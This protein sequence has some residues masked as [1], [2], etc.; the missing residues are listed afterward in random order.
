MP[1]RT[2]ESECFS[3]CLGDCVSLISLG[4]SA[5]WIGYLDASASGGDV[6]FA[7]YE[8]RLVPQD[9]DSELDFYDARVDG[10]FP[11]PAS[12]AVCEG[13]ACQGAPAAAAIFGA[14]ASATFSGAGNLAPRVLVP[15]K[16]VVLTRAERLARALKVCRKDKKHSKRRA[17][18][19]Q[20]RKRFSKRSRSH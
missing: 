5:L 4:R 2:S 8:K 17:C 16:P 15:S 20:A 9:G 12:S 3:A 14:P 10:G 6:F 1:S 19:R 11:A 13:E 18:E 7:R